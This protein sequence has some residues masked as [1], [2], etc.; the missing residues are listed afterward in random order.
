[1]FKYHISLTTLR[2][3]GNMC[4]TKTNALKIILAISILGL[5]FSGYLSYTELFQEVCSLSGGCST[6]G[7]IPACVFGFVMYLVILVI[8]VLGL[9]SRGKK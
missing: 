6:I 7:D 1:M 3:E 4:I 9:K 5:L 2:K 8:S